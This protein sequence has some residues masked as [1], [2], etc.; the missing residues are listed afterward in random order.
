VPVPEWLNGDFSDLRNGSGQLIAIYDPFSVS[1]NGSQFVRAPFAG[2]I[3]PKDHIDPVALKVM[4]YYPK[5]NA[6]PNN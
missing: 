1:Q 2:N 6:I 5:P 4:T 3:I